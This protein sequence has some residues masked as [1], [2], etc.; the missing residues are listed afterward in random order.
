MRRVLKSFVH[1][2]HLNL[3]GAEDVWLFAQLR[4]WNEP[5]VSIDHLVVMIRHVHS[6]LEVDHEFANELLVAVLKHILKDK[7]LLFEKNVDELVL[8]P[9]LQLVEEH[10]PVACQVQYYWADIVSEFQFEVGAHVFE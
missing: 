6:E 3:L 8:E 1:E 4:H 10:V 7:V 2:W 5:I 9:R